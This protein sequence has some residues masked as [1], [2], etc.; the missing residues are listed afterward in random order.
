MTSP[1]RR[2]ALRSV[3]LLVAGLV[4]GIGLGA[5][6]VHRSN[7]LVLKK[8]GGLV[9]SDALAQALTSQS[10]NATDP[11]G[12]VHIGPSFFAKAGYYCRTFSLTAAPAAAGLACRIGNEWQ[13]QVWAQWSG[14]GAP[15][16]AA[17]PPDLVD[18]VG[19]RIAGLPLDQVG[20]LSALGRGWQPAQ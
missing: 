11:S 1:V 19:R 7:P 5:L 3:A 16:A 14:S 9:A 15:G 13:I 17:L 8:S 18:A 6:V 20:E 12:M 4:L 10:G 2:P